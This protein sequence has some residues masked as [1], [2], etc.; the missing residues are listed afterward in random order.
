MLKTVISSND[1]VNTIVEIKNVM[2]PTGYKQ[3]K[4]SSE[5]DHARRDGSEQVQY[6]LVLSPTQLKNLK[7]IL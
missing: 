2:S 1:G 5:W 4:F 7:D 3:I 6:T